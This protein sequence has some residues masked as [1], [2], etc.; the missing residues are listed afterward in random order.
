MKYILTLLL[1][2]LSIQGAT[3]PSPTVELSDVQATCNMAT[4]RLDI[5][6]LPAGVAYWTTNLKLTN[7]PITIIGAGTNSTIIYDEN[8]TRSAQGTI[9]LINLLGTSPTNYFRLSGIQFR[10]AV[11]NTARGFSG[12]IQIKSTFNQFDN[13]T[14]RVDNCFFNNVN[15]RALYLGAREGLIDHCT[16]I[17]ASQDG[18]VIDSRKSTSTTNYGDLAWTWPIAYGT[19]DEGVYFEDCS[20]NNFTIGVSAIDAFGGTQYVLRY[21]NLRNTDAGGH[22]TE[23]SV[24]PRSVRWGARYMNTWT[25]TVTSEFASLFRGGSGVIFSNAVISVGGKGRGLWRAVN[26]RNTQSFSYWGGAFG[27]NAWDTNSSTIFYSGN[28]TASNNATSTLTDTNASWT[29][30]QW[31]GYSVFATNEVTKGSFITANTATTLTMEDDHNGDWYSFTNG[32]PYQIRLNLRAIDQLGT[33]EG[34][35]VT[36]H[37]AVP[38]YPDQITNTMYFW[39]NTGLTNFAVQAS[40]NMVSGRD[41]SNAVSP[42]YVTYTYPH[43]LIALTTD[44]GIDVQPINQE[45]ESGNPATNTVTA[46]GTAPFTYQWYNGSSGDTSAPIPSATDATYITGNLTAS[47]NYWVRITNANGTIDSS[48]AIITVVSSGEPPVITT[49]PQ[50]VVINDGAN[51]VFTVTA[52][53]TDPLT[54]QWY[55]GESGDTGNPI[56]GATDAIYNSPALHNDT[57]Y[58]VRVTNAE[59]SAD[60]DT[61]FVDVVYSTRAVR[62]ENSSTQGRVILR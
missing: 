32:Q 57:F 24:E 33:G 18:N 21:S 41:Y 23:T 28:L 58:W 26:Y 43:P 56:G 14:F 17:F 50:S 53:G 54:Y 55:E 6:T 22:G 31:V 48:T 4:N 15:N 19:A 38:T 7:Q 5:V 11:T 30:N 1:T 61:A 44:P 10:G 37:Q 45:I 20:F 29:I 42:T 9:A 47:S 25:Y 3:F 8:P 36:A 34:A 12:A 2:L 49:Q 35:L 62:L 13:P 51:A 27:Q 39:A 16:F 40:L 52:T 60:S 59:G 46:S